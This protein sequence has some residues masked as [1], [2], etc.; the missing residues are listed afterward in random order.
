[1]VTFQDEMLG[2]PKDRE[3]AKRMLELLSGNKQVVITAVCY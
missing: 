2:K 1:M 3:D